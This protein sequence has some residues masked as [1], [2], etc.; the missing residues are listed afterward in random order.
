MGS[1]DPIPTWCFAL[2]VVRRGDAFVLVH[3]RKFG[4]TFYLP[5]GRVEPGET[6]A[7]GALRETKEEAGLDVVLDGVLRVEHSPSSDGTARLRVIFLAHPARAS[8][9]LKSRPD[10]HSLGARWVT[11]QELRSLP[12]RGD[13][14]AAVL[15]YVARGGHVAPLSSLTVEGADW[16]P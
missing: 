16:S 2:V 9:P 8:A 14:V 3:E 5:G 10:E 4:Q 1:R 7:Q 6:L 13:E 15:G 12:L 11:L